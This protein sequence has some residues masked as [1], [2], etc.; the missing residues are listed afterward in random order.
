MHCLI[1]RTPPTK[2][3]ALTPHLAI[4]AHQCLRQLMLQIIAI[5]ACSNRPLCLQLLPSSRACQHLRASQSRVTLLLP[6]LLLPLC[7]IHCSRALPFRMPLQFQIHLQAFLRRR[8]PLLV[9]MPCCP[10]KRT[11]TCQLAESRGLPNSQRQRLQTRSPKS[12]PEVAMRRLRTPGAKAAALNNQPSTSNSKSS[13]I[14]SSNKL[15]P[16]LPQQ[17]SC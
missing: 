10:S 17:N 2:S 5:L 8:W 13:F 3:L 14:Y 9:V 15:L 7:P 12:V 16:K 4:L 11:S 1:H 6:M